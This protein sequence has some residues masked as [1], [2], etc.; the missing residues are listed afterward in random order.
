MAVTRKRVGDNVVYHLSGLLDAETVH[1]YFDLNYEDYHVLGDAIGVIIDFRELTRPTIS[2]L[3]AAQSRMKGVVFDT[4]VAFVGRP[5]SILMA[6]LS[7]LEALSSQTRRRFR[8]FRE[9][10]DPIADASDWI[11]SWYE[12]HGLDRDA[13]RGQITANPTPPRGEAEK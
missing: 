13:I 5:D 10:D 2:G 7:G 6:F 4:P 11:D 9:G 3:S 12:L 8:F 1:Q